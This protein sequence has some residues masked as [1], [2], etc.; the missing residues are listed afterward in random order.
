MNNEELVLQQGMTQLDS[1][2]AFRIELNKN[3]SN[4][5]WSI[6][7]QKKSIPMYLRQ[8]LYLIE[9]NWEYVQQVPMEEL[10][11]VLNVL[12]LARSQGYKKYSYMYDSLVF[13][14]LDESFMN[15]R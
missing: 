9:D 14:A 10:Y 15:S 2:F 12:K 1:V 4:L 11:M 8:I 13:H 7:K 6:R 5:C 3:Y